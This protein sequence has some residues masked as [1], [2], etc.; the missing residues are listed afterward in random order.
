VNSSAFQPWCHQGI[1][2]DFVDSVEPIFQKLGCET[3]RVIIP[4][5]LIKQIPV[6]LRGPRVNLVAT[7]DY[8]QIEDVTIYAHM[9]V[10]PIDEEWSVNPFAGIIKEGKVYGRGASDMKTSI[11]TMIVAIEILNEL[12]L[13]PNFNLICMLCTDEEIGN[14]PG[15]YHLAKEGYVKGHIINTELGAQVPLMFAAAGIVDFVIR[16]KGKSAHSGANFLG[17]NAIEE[18]IPILNELMKLKAEVERRESEVASIPLFKQWGAP[19]DKMTPMFNLDIIQGGTKANIVP[20]ECELLVNRRY[21]SEEDIEDVAKEFHEAVERGK[22]KSKALA[23]EVEEQRGYPPFKTDLKSSRLKKMTEALKAVYGYKDSDMFF[24]G[25][26]GSTDMGFIK[27]WN[28][29]VDIIGLGA[30][31]PMTAHG[32]DEYVDINS[33]V[34]MTKQLIH[35]LVF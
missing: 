5:E 25:I 29:Q 19:S 28:D 8:G 12:Q 17:I 18:T 30:F 2:E 21:L 9:D 1:T 6:P 34:G 26:S 32:A 7:K 10:V 11:A 14:Y 23:V 4:D 27:Q 15:I 33:L 24:A 3:E 31:E 20:S 35:Y 22:A 13:T 16:V